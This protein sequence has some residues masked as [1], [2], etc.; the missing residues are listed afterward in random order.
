MTFKER[1]ER[2]LNQWRK[3]ETKSKKKSGEN[4]EYTE[5]EQLLID[6]TGLCEEAELKKQT[7]EKTSKAKDRD[8]VEAGKAVREAAMQAMVKRKATKTLEQLRDL[9][10]DENSS[11]DDRTPSKSKKSRNTKAPEADPLMELLNRKLELDTQKEERRRAE[12]ENQ[13]QML[14]LL[15]E[16]LKK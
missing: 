3:D 12:M 6:I 7:K 10:S 2:L 15:I 5:K 8:L 14:R 16:T 13:Q 9:E 4:E 1:I 11:S